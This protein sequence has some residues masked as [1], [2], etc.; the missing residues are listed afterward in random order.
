MPRDSAAII[1]AVVAGLIALGNGIVTARLASRIQEQQRQK[2]KAEQLADVMAR[3]RDPM[4]RAAF[5]L[6]SR[7]YNIA[8]LGFLETHYRDETPQRKAYAAE[9][10]LF[11]LAEYL[12]WVE[13]MR[14]EVRFL[15]L[16]DEPVNRRLAEH[17][18]TVRRTL[19][20]DRHDPLLQLFSGQQRAIGELM[21]VPSGASESRLAC[22]GFATFVVRLRDDEDFAGWFT[23]L[24]ADI[25]ELARA[26]HSRRLVALQ[27]ALIDL[28]DLLDEGHTRLPQSDLQ[29]LPDT[30]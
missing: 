27:H 18:H 8:A 9:S 16:G 29:R 30:A 20:S 11:V 21:A 5:D 1:L 23:Q 12:G 4:L 15:D 22:M 14:R 17:L 24:R 10:T 6:Q 19:L 3:Y 13:I 25:H 7:L 28:I 26:P 2:T